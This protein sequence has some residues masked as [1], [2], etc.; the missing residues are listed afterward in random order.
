MNTIVRLALLAALQLGFAGSARAQQAAADAVIGTWTLVSETALH[1]GKTTEPL[2]P[3]PLGCMMLDRGGRF[4]LMIARSDLPRFAAGKR[5]AGTPEENKAVLAGSLSFFGTYRLDG[6]GGVLILRPEA[7]TFPNW[8]GADQKRQL[9]L[10]GD[11]MKW[12]NRAPA[13]GA[14]VVEVVWRRAR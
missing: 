11:E 13:I 1:G 7:S 4:I 8:V 14:E 5:E 3:H 12:V 9:T 2:G 10:S 6:A